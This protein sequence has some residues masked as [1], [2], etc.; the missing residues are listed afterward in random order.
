MRAGKESG[1][2]GARRRPRAT[3]RVG[4]A[5]QHCVVAR[6]LGGGEMAPVREMAPNFPSFSVCDGEVT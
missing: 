6:D 5:A 1:R 3:G 4:R 2:V